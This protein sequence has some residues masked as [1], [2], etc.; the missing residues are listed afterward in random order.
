VPLYSRARSGKRLFA[1]WRPLP[2]S[3]KTRL[4]GIA[5][6]SHVNRRGATAFRVTEC[7]ARQNVLA[8]E[9]PLTQ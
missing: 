5:G 3:D 7:R 1:C 4:Q 6:L 9:Y 2:R 8:R